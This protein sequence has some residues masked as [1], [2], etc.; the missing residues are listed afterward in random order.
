MIQGRY[1]YSTGGVGNGE[2]FRQPYTQILSMATNVTSDRQQNR[3]P[4]SALNETCCA[5]NLAKLTKDLNCFNPDDAKYMDYYERVLYNKLV[6]SLAPEWY[7]VTYHYAVGLNASKQ[8]GDADHPGNANP[9]SSCCGGT[10]SENHVKYQEAAY[11]ASE[12]TL[13][14]GLYMPTTL[15][16]D[17]KNVVIQQDCLW[18]AE[19]S[20]IRLTQGTANFTLKLR[21]PYWATGGFDIKLNGVSIASH[22][23]PSSYVTIP[24]R[25]WTTKD[26]VEITMPFDK[27]IDYG[28]D[29]ME[30]AATG[31]NET[32]TPFVP[33]WAGTFMYG[34]LAMT[35]NGIT[36]WNEA[37]ITVNPSLEDILL[38]G[39]SGGTTGADGNLYTL[40]HGDRTFQP[41]YYRNTNST[42]Y[43]RIN[44]TGYP[45]NAVYDLDFADRVNKNDLLELLNIAQARKVAQDTWN[46]LTVKVPDYPPWAPHGF[47][48]LMEQLTLAQKVY[49]DEDKNY[50]QAEVNAIASTLNA[51]INTM[52]PGNLPEL[53]DL[54]E[55]LTLLR[56]AKAISSPASL[57][58]EAIAYTEMVVEY[59]GNG[60]GT[61]DMIEAAITKLNA[62]R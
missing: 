4:S 26:V 13:W 6:G 14:V 45:D 46:A 27:H 24:A 5:Y 36:N 44:I 15:T 12:N 19:S 3:N 43:F 20:T 28:P 39:P 53:E 7:G 38:N 31:Q 61:H 35:A 60:S 30:M 29:K 55:L 2:M 21:V 32:N 54:G 48:R 34:P 18:P 50:S 11:F 41:D 37:T 49:G 47:S 51:I 42:H 10:G 58:T 25:N 17:S 52:R 57:M 16:W 9:H 40:T 23:Q 8:W 22:Y 59:V 62:A 1:R 56:D 33:L